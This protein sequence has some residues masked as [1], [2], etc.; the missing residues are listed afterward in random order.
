MLAPIKVV[1]LDRLQKH[2]LLTGWRQICWILPISISLFT[3]FSWNHN[4]LNLIL[5]Q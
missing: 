2:T 3:L 4:W 5:A 1:P